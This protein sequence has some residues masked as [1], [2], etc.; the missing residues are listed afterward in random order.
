MALMRIDHIQLAMP[1]GKEDQARR[2]YAATLGLQEVEKPENLA[3]RGGWWFEQGA[4]RV[5]LG[6][7]PDF[8]AAK[9]AHPAFIVGNLDALRDK[10]A[11]AGYEVQDDEPLAGYTRTYVYD[12]FGNRIELMQPLGSPPLAGQSA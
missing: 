2:F 8:R 7:D 12:P 4:I 9:K 1:A 5:H 3:K 11:A 10:L 6:V